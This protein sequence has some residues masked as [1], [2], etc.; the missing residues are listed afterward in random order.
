MKTLACLLAAVLIGM[1]PARALADGWPLHDQVQHSFCLS[2]FGHDDDGPPAYH[3]RCFGG[4]AVAVNWN[5]MKVQPAHGKSLSM[6][7]DDNTEFATDSGEGVL[8]GLSSGDYVCVTY[9]QRRKS[10]MVLVVVFDLRP[11]PCRAPPPHS[12]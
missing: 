9:A 3:P 5:S 1:F 10:N 12:W 2:H 4:V 8:D 6:R 7:F 11:L